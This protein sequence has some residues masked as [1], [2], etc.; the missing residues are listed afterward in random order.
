MTYEEALDFLYTQLPVYQKV[1]KKAF[2]KDLGKTLQ[3]CRYLDNPENNFQ[4]IHVAGTNGKGSAAH[5]IA[6]VL[7]EAGYKV[8]LYTSPHLKSFRERIR[9]NGSL[10]DRDFLPGFVK[11]IQ[12]LI[13]EIEPSFFEI[14][15]AMAFQYFSDRK[16]DLA[17]IETGLGGRFDSTNVI[18]PKLS[19]IT[20]IGMDHT[21]ILGDSLELIAGEKAGIIKNNT[22]VVVGA[23]DEISERVIRDVAKEKNASFYRASDHFSIESSDGGIFLRKIEKDNRWMLKSDLKGESLTYNASLV[24]QSIHVLKGIG[25]TIEV[26]ELISGLNAVCKNTGLKGR[27]Q[28][29]GTHP[30]MVCDIGHNEQAVTGLVEEISGQDFKSLHVVWGMVKDK[31]AEKVLSLLPEDAIYYFC[32]PQLERALPAE[33]LHRVATQVGL[34]GNQYD[35]VKEAVAMAKSTANVEDMIFVGGSTF[36][37]AELDEI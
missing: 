14:T 4:S 13:D 35:S 15:V 37:V 12:P 31:A 28:V 1:G 20:S 6:S 25:Y 34:T 21:D 19:V 18:Q 22:P 33:E 30:L 8:G 17:V 2:N 27:W 24:A 7:Q 10:M 3:L 5:M 29:L 11:K 16:V 32:A 26:E 36:V 23:L 9:I